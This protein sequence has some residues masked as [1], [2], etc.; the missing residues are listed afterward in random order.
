MAGAKI[1]FSKRHA[2][3]RK[4]FSIEPVLIGIMGVSLPMM[5]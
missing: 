2:E 3:R 5:S 1:P 4:V